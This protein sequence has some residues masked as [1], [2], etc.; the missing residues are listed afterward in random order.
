ME[1][2]EWVDNDSL[3]VAYLYSEGVKVAALA[4]DRTEALP[5]FEMV[6][7]IDSLHAPSHYQ[8]GDMVVSGDSERGLYH[9]QIAYA[10]DST[11]VDYLGLYG[12]ALLGRRDIQEAKRVYEKLVKL[13]PHHAYNYQVLASLYKAS[14]MPYMALS[15]LD[16]AEYKLGLRADI[17]NQKLSLLYSMELYDRAIVEIEK[18]LSNNPRNP[19]RITML[20]Y[21]Y[22]QTKQDSLAE[23]SFK[24]AL[25]LN[26]QSRDA[27]LGLATLYKQ[28]GRE[29]ELLQTLKTILLSE[30]LSLD[31]AISI[32][33]E[34]LLGDKEF[35]RRNFFTIKSLITSFHLKHSDDHSVIRCYA[36]FLVGTGEI[37][38]GLELYKQ[39]SRERD[40][41]PNDD[42]EMVLGGEGYLGHADSV[43]HYI[44]LS[45]ENHPKLAQPYL[46]KG[47]E[48]LRLGGE[49]SVSEARKLFK[50][51]LKLEW[52]SKSKSDIYC[53]LAS[54]ETSPQKRIKLFKKALQE[55]RYNA[56]ALNNWAYELC[57][58]GEDLELA[59][60]M[61]NEACEEEPS[62]PTYLDT[63]AW[64]LFKMGDLQEAKKIM[65]QAIS[66]DNSGDSVFLLHYGDILAAEGDA[67]M[68]EIYYKR[69]LDAGEDA[70]VIEKRI[71]ALK[72]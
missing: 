24:E 29:V 46:L 61:S 8:V 4:E 35:L 38:R 37:E 33:E 54:L 56:T 17:M 69:A 70:E 15:I 65:R 48:I 18:E 64:I 21:I 53:N 44:N 2:P 9:G 71:E 63:K 49:K 12:Y 41:T 60:E 19:E 1:I 3:R 55:Y 62:E 23:H 27:L 16:S 36:E 42:L 10:A 6:F 58:M 5:Y 25:A 66:L 72:R 51:A 50:K 13:E 31:E 47:Y 26:P 57:E 68:A 52:Y 7:E 11:N 59:L 40:Y 34:D 28:A 39:L 67:F 43:M 22:V 14:N 32:I 30:I 45:I 20:G